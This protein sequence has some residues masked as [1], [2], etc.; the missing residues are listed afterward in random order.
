M[1]LGV[2]EQQKKRFDVTVCGGTL[3]I[4]VATA[5]ALKGLHVAVVEK[6]VLRGVSG[7]SIA[8]VPLRWYFI[9]HRFLTMSSDGLSLIAADSRVEYIQERVV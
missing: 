6:D 2:A 3:G 8:F 7:M 1:S 4:F 5:L 9:A